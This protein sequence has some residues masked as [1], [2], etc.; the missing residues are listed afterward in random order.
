MVAKSSHFSDSKVK[1]HVGSQ[2][3]SLPHTA[4]GRPGAVG[5]HVCVC[6]A[7]MC[8]CMCVCMH[9]LVS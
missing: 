9:V 4:T 7:W 8:A 1:T 2:D 3:V 6:V 5:V